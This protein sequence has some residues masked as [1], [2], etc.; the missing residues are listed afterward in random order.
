[1]NLDM[2]LVAGIIWLWIGYKL[3][4]YFVA[5]NIYYTVIPRLTSDPVNE[6]FG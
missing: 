4:L 2:R 1:M 5:L 6:F 3:E